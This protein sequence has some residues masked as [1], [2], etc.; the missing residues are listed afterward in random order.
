LYPHKNGA[1]NNNHPYTSGLPTIGTILHEQGY[2]TAMIGKFLHVTLPNTP[3]PGWDFWM[4]KE[5]GGKIDP[6][7]NYNGTVVQTFGHELDIVADTAIHV[8]SSKAGQQPFLMVVSFNTP[9]SPY[10][11]KPEDVGAFAGESMPFPEN[12][13]PQENNYPSFYK[14]LSAGI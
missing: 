4:A 8:L 12:F 10:E 14:K 2:Y 1:V 5:A 13:F 7:Y 3:E 6:S 11:P 9:H